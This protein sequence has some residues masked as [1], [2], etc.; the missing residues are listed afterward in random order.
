MDRSNFTDRAI[1]AN[2]V[3][4]VL[5]PGK[6]VDPAG[7]GK[8]EKNHIWPTIF[9]LLA[10][11]TPAPSRRPHI[12]RGCRHEG[13]VSQNLRRRRSRP[14]GRGVRSVGWRSL[15]P[16]RRRPISP[17]LNRSGPARPM[18]I[19]SA[20]AKSPTCG[21]SPPACGGRRPVSATPAGWCSSSDGSRRC[22]RSGR[23]RTVMVRSMS[24]SETRLWIFRNRAKS[25][26]PVS[27]PAGADWS[28][29]PAS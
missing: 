7:A 14:S 21:R 26:A 12:S 11:M 1:A 20:P 2:L 5:I 25:R 9:S 17:C 24:R 29:G 22:P 19:A 4:E 13:K 6:A 27:S 18:S 10:S 28:R 8:C 3:T 15:R 16:V 23:C